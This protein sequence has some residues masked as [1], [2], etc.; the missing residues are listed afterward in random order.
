M[1]NS[2]MS[3]GLSGMQQSQRKMQQAAQDIVQAGIATDG[4][5]QNVTATGSVPSTNSGTS[6]TDLAATSTVEASQPNERSTGSDRR[7]GDIVQSLVEQKQ[8]Q[9]VFDASANI[10]QSAN[11]TMG[12]LID[13]L[14]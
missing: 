7:T 12:K 11:E 13:D 5:Q 6:V 1:L 4:G 14:S 3:E 2:V 10:V 9:L 8:Q